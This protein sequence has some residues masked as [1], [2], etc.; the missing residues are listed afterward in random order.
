MET[1]TH[2][3]KNLDN[4]SKTFMSSLSIDGY[5]SFNPE[6]KKTTQY[7]LLKFITKS[8]LNEKSKTDKNVLKTIIDG[9]QMRSSENENYELSELS[10]DLKE[11]LDYMFNMS[12]EEII[13]KNG[14]KRKIID[15]EENS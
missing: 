11:N 3:I 14:K 4:I 15:K 6:K 5:F 13:K 1:K 8:I 10:K 2:L 9:L 7:L 12:S